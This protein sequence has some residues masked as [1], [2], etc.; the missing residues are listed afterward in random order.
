MREDVLAERGQEIAEWRDGQR[1]P[2]D[3]DG[4]RSEGGVLRRL[5]G[6]DAVE[7]ALEAIEIGE[8]RCRL[9]VAFVGDVVGGAR[10]AVDRKDGIPLRARQQERRHRKVFVVSGGHR[11]RNDSSDV[12]GTG[13]TRAR[14]W[15]A[16]P[17]SA[18]I[19]RSA[20]AAA[21]I[22]CRTPE[23]RRRGRA[24]GA[25]GCDSRA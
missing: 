24:K 15:R 2:R 7:R 9:R 12:G 13:R 10:E 3:R 19:A 18:I 4:E 17:A 21:G 1:M 11:A 20:N 8:A 14:L 16:G 25:A 5:P 22:R 6:G 23:R